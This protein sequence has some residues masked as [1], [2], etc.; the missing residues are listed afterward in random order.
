MN[1][2]V[3]EMFCSVVTLWRAD[4]M[5]VLWG[6]KLDKPAHLTP[7]LQVPSFYTK[8]AQA[9]LLAEPP[10]DV[11]HA[12]ACN[13]CCAVVFLLAL[14]QGTLDSHS[15]FGRKLTNRLA[16]TQAMMIAKLSACCTH[17]WFVGLDAVSGR[18]SVPPMMYCCTSVLFPPSSCLLYLNSEARCTAQALLVLEC[19]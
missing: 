12:G 3:M 17:Y 2:A 10:R 4:S 19:D 16:K 8:T 13:L 11:P 5:L 15:V 6:C 1:A 18:A 9:S 7:F 14:W